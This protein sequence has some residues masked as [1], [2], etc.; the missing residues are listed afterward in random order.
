MPRVSHQQAMLFSDPTADRANEELEPQAESG[1]DTGSHW[2]GVPVQTFRGTIEEISQHVPKFARRPFTAPEEEGKAVGL[3]PYYDLIVRLPTTE[4][5]FE[6]PVGI[7]SK[8]Y[9]LVQHREV[10]DVASA[11]LTAA[12]I[13]PGKVDVELTITENGERARL[14]LAFPEGDA[15]SFR[16]SDRDEMRLRLECLN[17]VDGST[18]FIAVLGWLRFVC[19]NGLVIGVVLANFREM[20]TRH[21]QLSDIGVVMKQALRSARNDRATY[22]RWLKTTV[23]EHQLVR[24]ADGPL[25]EAWG[26]KAATRVFHIA[27]IGRDPALQGDLRKASPSRVAVEPG[28]SVPGSL[29]PAKNAF[30]ISQA[31]SWIT[32]QRREV[33]EQ[34]EW[35]ASIPGLIKKLIALA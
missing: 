1:R 33:T 19:S 2:L 25:K 27:R 7:V 12:E 15:Y 28:K 17:S 13:D 35:R 23:D 32:G 5:P 34:L 31:L 26:L 11:A 16:I 22:S 21:L 6:F 29:A 10:L 18:R 3:S 8:T 30:A 9:Q 4:H 24:W 20:H 14:A